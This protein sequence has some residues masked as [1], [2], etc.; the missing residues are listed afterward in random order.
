[1]SENSRGDFLTH[2]V[3]STD[4]V[5]RCF[6]YHINNDT[7][8]QWWENARCYWYCEWSLV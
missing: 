1:M 3:L 6:N 7:N 4:A 2:T 5:L 8:E